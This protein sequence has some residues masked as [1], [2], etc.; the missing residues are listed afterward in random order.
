MVKLEVIFPL[1][2]RVILLFLRQFI[3][4]KLSF[5]HFYFCNLFRLE[6]KIEKA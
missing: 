5:P 1:V 3:V 2:L 4:C 6:N